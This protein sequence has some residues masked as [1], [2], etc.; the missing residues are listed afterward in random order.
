VVLF[1]SLA[2]AIAPASCAETLQDAVTQAVRTNP[3]ALEAINRRLAAD[4]GVKGAR[5]GYFPRLDVN[6]GIGRERLD[7]AYARS[8]GMSDTTFT[9]RQAVVTLTQ[10]LFDGFAVRSAV[11]NQEARVA[12]SASRVAVTAEDLALR[13]ASAY[14]EVLRRQETVIA[15]KESFNAHQRIYQ[16]IKRRS[17]SGVGRGADLV[18]AQ[19]RVALA[20]DTLRGEES[21]LTEA[22]LHYL[23]L[24]GARPQEL[25]KPTLPKHALP[26]GE[27]G[28]VATARRDHPALKVAEADVAAAEAQQSAA[29]AR[30][31]PTLELELAANHDNDRLRGLADD[32]AIM[33]RVRYNLFQGGTD[34][35]RVNE[36]GFQV[37]ELKETLART[38]L[39]VE[40]AAAVTFNATVASRDRLTALSDYVAS[41]ALTREA[42]G[43]QFNIG[44]RSLL[45]LLNSEIEY[46]NARF[47]Y[48]TGQYS[49]MA[50][51]YQLLASMGHLLSALEVAPPLQA[52]FART[53]TTVSRPDR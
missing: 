17:E 7:D 38:R 26:A 13:V 35:A 29:K 41:S 19:A 14:L 3:E 52:N 27:S 21:S 10:M 47:A 45:D 25:S 48:I 46:Y 37:R 44:Q 15:A 20:V 4:E 8:L 22:E 39:Q 50:S 43:K 5:G 12:G 32:R 2:A 40:E 9:R 34:R 28:A 53:I 11:A 1:G 33:L 18:Q 30:F 31:Y 49:E 6:A 51:T 42:Y 36:A 23:R 16:Q 24:V